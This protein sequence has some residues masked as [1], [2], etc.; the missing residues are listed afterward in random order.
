MS[1]N[2][3]FR[4]SNFELTEIKAEG[5]EGRWIGY[6]SIFGNKDSAGDIVMPGAFANTL[7]KSG[8]RPLPCL[9]QHNRQ[10]PVG[11]LNCKEDSKGLECS[12]E[13]NLDV[14]KAREAY[15]LLKQGAISGLSIG[16]RTIV[17]EFDTKTN[18]RFLKELDLREV[19][20]VTFPCNPLTHVGSVKQATTVREFEQ[21]LR[22]AGYSHSQAKHIASKGF[23]DSENL[24]DADDEDESAAKQV[25]E[26]LRN[27]LALKSFTRELQNA[28]R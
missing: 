28:N 16:Y 2:Q 24:R 7:R 21:F 1:G 10:E 5:T 3:G 20:L 15:S 12:G 14:Q 8:G 23:K 26:E 11:I 18:T 9:W 17:D 4:Q 27:S 19:S 6:G 25:L 13:L 22:D